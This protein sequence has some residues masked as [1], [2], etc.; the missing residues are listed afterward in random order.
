VSTS[1]E[2]LLLAAVRATGR[3]FDALH[4]WTERNS[5]LPEVVAIPAGSEPRLDLLCEEAVSAVKAALVAIG[6]RA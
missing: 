3:Y 1:K 6:D 2:D 4:A 5:D